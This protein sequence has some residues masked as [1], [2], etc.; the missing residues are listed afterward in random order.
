MRDSLEKRHPR[1]LIDIAGPGQGPSTT[2]NNDTT[3]AGV[4]SPLRPAAAA[5]V[6]HAVAVFLCAVGLAAP[7]AHA[8]VVVLTDTTITHAIAAALADPRDAE[9]EHGRIADWDVK[10]LT[11]GNALFNEAFVFN[12]DLAAWDVRACRL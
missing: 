8:R 1:C 3:M 11:T 5:V 12:A 9:Q 7:G 4:L 10:A 6:L 2:D